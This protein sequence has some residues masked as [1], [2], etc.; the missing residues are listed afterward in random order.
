M[1][2]VISYENNGQK[3]D[4]PNLQWKSTLNIGSDAVNSVYQTGAGLADVGAG[5]ALQNSSLGKKTV[6]GKNEIENAPTENVQYGLKWESLKRESP[7]PEKYSEYFDGLISGSEI[8]SGLDY[9][10]LYKT[11]QVLGE[12][13]TMYRDQL[14]AI[15]VADELVIKDRLIPSAFRRES[16]KSAKE[17]YEKNLKEYQTGGK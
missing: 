1:I 4:I 10:R 15:G 6:I 17:N 14:S 8:S 13:Y 5:V 12:W 2:S 16:L 11:S 9:F 7:S 3:S